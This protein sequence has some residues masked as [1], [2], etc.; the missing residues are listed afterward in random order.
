MFRS[1]VSRDDY[2]LQVQEIVW[3]DAQ[4][5]YYCAGPGSIH[6]L[7]NYTPDRDRA[8][9]KTLA[10]FVSNT[11][12]LNSKDKAVYDLRM[13][14]LWGPN[15]EVI[16][17]EESFQIYR[18]LWD[19]QQR[20]MEASED[21]NTLR[22]GLLELPNLTRITLTREAWRLHH[23]FPLYETPFFR[24][25]KPGMR[26]VYPWP[27]LGEESSE[28]R[29]EEQNKE[30]VRSPWDQ[31]HQEWRGYSIVVSEM[32]STVNHHKVCEFLIDVHREQTGISQQLFCTPNLDLANTGA[33]FQA[34]DLT[35]LDLALNMEG[36]D[37]GD[38]DWWHSKCFWNYPWLKRAFSRLHN[39]KH[40]HLH[41]S[42]MKDLVETWEEDSDHPWISLQDILP[43]PHE[44]AWPY[45][46]SL[47]LAN[48]LTT[49]NSL[50]T[51]LAALPALAYID[52]DSMTFRERD[53][54]T[55]K[56]HQDFP[57]RRQAWG[58]AYPQASMDHPLPQRRRPQPRH[59]LQ[60]R[61]GSFLYG[62]G[63][64]PFLPRGQR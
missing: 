15:A 45:L 36:M 59:A 44:T 16:S 41:L 8:G 47:G 19:E 58:L 43:T 56:S 52:L 39:L 63:D 37:T 9:P 38:R 62:N 48:I 53:P 27:W 18:Q 10:D 50:Y 54:V 55:S 57:R 31:P 51:L 64:N 49:E 13:T 6:D 21:V 46:R 17:A 29:E 4:L 42:T 35:Q 3:D 32:L 24:S 23:F 28:L 2:K 34:L 60:R 11:D 7:D 1:V 5:E 22:L 20:I 33:L 61:I 12:F 25:L 14:E 40:F 30:R 26:M